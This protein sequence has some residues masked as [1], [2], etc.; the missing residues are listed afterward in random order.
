MTGLPIHRFD[1]HLVEHVH[2][3]NGRIGQVYTRTAVSVSDNEGPRL[4]L[5]HPESPLV[6][7]GMEVPWEA[8]R[9]GRMV[10]KTGRLVWVGDLSLR[11]TGEGQSLRSDPAGWSADKM[12][13]R[14]SALRLPKRTRALLGL[15]EC[16]SRLEGKVT[17][18]IRTELELL[19]GHLRN[20]AAG[21]ERYRGIVGKLAGLGPGST[22]TGDDLLLGVCALAWRLASAG[23]IGRESLDGFAASLAELPPDKTTPTGREMLAHAA[24]GS[25]F[26]TLLR[27]V[28][29]LGGQTTPEGLASA[30]EQLEQTGG[31]SG[32]DMLAGVV[33]LAW[34]FAEGVRA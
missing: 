5:L 16:S 1:R 25:F 22:P 14:L 10:A 9:P 32:F 7:C 13:E 4:A 28:D 34:A 8:V 12:D 27:F 26:E 17:A 3:F 18:A 30:A 29:A 2:T 23:L 21:I 11:L 31:R 15:C 24:R 20:G 33:A 6:P 19:V